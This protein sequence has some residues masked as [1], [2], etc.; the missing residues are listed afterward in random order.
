MPGQPEA[1]AGR[2]SARRLIVL[3]RQP[4]RNPLGEPVKHAYPRG[5]HLGTG[6][7]RGV[8]TSL[9]RAGRRDGGSPRATRAHRGPRAR[10]LERYLP[11]D[12]RQPLYRL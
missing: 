2:S 5:Q 3:D 10:V 7:A 6:V 8:D 11:K 12:R 9:R 1:R 4:E